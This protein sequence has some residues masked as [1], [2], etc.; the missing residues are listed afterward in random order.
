MYF[1]LCNSFEANRSNDTINESALQMP[2][3]YV[4]V[5]N[6]DEYGGAYKVDES[7]GVYGHGDERQYTFMGRPDMFNWTKG[8]T[9]TSMKAKIQP[10][11]ASLW[12]QRFNGKPKDNAKRGRK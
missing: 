10:V 8:I 1:T 3:T 7:I 6:E 9:Y 2:I 5:T 12:R 4:L 11:Q